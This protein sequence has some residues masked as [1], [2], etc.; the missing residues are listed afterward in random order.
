MQGLIQIQSGVQVAA[1]GLFDD[2]P[3]P[4]SVLVN[5]AR[6]SCPAYHRGNRGVERRRQGQMKKAIP[7][8]VLLLVE[9][10]KKAGQLSKIRERVVAER[11]IPYPCRKLLPAA[12]VRH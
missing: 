11:E 6:K 2:D 12:H 3:G 8:G 5:L 10:I 7:P 4:A 1:K 9:G